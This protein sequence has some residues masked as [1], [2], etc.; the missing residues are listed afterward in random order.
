MVEQGF[1]EVA[2][3]A[4]VVLRVEV[5]E[6]A[7]AHVGAAVRRLHGIAA[8]YPHGP[9]DDAARRLLVA[10]DVEAAWA[11]H[12]EKVSIIDSSLPEPVL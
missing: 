7:R 5:G 6:S 8:H 11:F 3:D 2:A 10:L 12:K 1:A 9:E 4:L